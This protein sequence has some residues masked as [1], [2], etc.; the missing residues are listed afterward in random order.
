MKQYK[1]SRIAAHEIKRTRPKISGIWLIYA[2]IFSV[3]TCLVILNLTPPLSRD[4]LIHHLAIP[5]L[6]LQNGGFYEIPWADFSYY[7]MY[8]NLLY[9]IPLYF[10]IDFLPKIIHM[11]FGIGTGVLVCKYITHQYNKQWGLLG[12]LI[13]ISTPIIIWLSTSAYIDLGMTFF[14]TASVL[15]LVK[16]REKSY[17]QLKWLVLSACCMGLAVGSKYNALIAWF[18]I[19][20]LLMFVYVRDTK[21]Q[22]SAIKYAAIFFFITLMVASPWF[23]KNYCFTQNPFYPLFNTFF[24][25][26]H[27]PA[28]AP[29]I[30][31]KQLNHN[32]GKINFFQFRGYLYGESFWE[33][34]F[35]PIRMFFQGNDLSYEHFQGRL[36]P[37]LLVFLPFIFLNRKLGRDKFVFLGFSVFFM[38]IAYFTTAKQVRYIVPVVPFLTILAVMGI[39]NLSA[40]WETKGTRLCK[41]FSVSVY[42]IVVMLLIPNFFYLKDHFKKIDPVPFI[43]GTETRNDYLKRH[44][45][46]Y[47]AVWFIN[48]QLP[49]DVVIYTIYLGR[50]GYYLE[51]D[52]KND[53]S[54]GVKVIRKLV[55]ASVDD[56]EFLKAINSLGATHIL[57]RTDLVDRFLQINY[58]RKEVVRFMNMAKKYLKLQYNQNKYT[59]W[60]LKNVQ[61]PKSHRRHAGL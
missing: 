34:L 25:A 18:I 36:N 21:H 57:M 1:N 31:E 41:I 11:L 29:E 35:I 56:E 45:L 30:L 27:A 32:A 12:L 23:I 4:A 44:L 46:H 5:K 15:A 6:W 28:N 33:T 10:R 42:I 59:V 39:N 19:N 16:W 9:L 3:V 26:I 43:M 2:A 13:F 60:E 47:E 7:P 52:Y 55:S 20:V 49:E 58:T 14:S 50:R 24:Q 17:E 38:F 22:L 40:Y 53:T 54:F 51:R 48:S 61:K 37:L 8:I